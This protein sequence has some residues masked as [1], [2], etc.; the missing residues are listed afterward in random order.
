[1]KSPDSITSEFYGLKEPL[2]KKVHYF[3]KKVVIILHNEIT[4]AASKGARL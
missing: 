3:T 2:T 4:A 1:M